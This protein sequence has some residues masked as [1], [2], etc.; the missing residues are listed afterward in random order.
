MSAT[1][2]DWAPPQNLL[3]QSTDDREAQHI[4]L[5]NFSSK[6]GQ[7][8]LTIGPMDQWTYLHSPASEKPSVIYKT[9][10]TLEKE[11]QGQAAILVRRGLLLSK[12]KDLTDD[13]EGQHFILPT[14]S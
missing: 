13:I 7:E 12:L 5:S 2:F 3:R 8:V 14:G 6:T 10:F 11:P 1:Y 4:S 9:K